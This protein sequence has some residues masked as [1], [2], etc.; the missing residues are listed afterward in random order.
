MPY[1]KLLGLAV[2]TAIAI[3]YVAMVFA[4]GWNLLAPPELRWISNDD[5]FRTSLSLL[6]APFITALI[7]AG[8]LDKS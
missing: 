1:M 7:T 3:I 5:L 8:I 6:A 2:L 4:A